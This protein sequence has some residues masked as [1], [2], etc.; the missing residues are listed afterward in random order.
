MNL[1]I[2]DIRTL[3]KTELWSWDIVEKT[4]SNFKKIAICVCHDREMDKLCGST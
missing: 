1:C 3:R 4:D 2:E